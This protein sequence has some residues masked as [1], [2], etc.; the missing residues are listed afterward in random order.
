VQW[1]V[2][3]RWA[4]CSVFIAV[5]LWLWA[6]WGVARA[7]AP[8]P[9]DPDPDPAPGATASPRV[10]LLPV[11]FEG[12]DDASRRALLESRLREG[13][14]SG[15]ATLAPA[16]APAPACTEAACWRTL[17]EAHDARYVVLARIVVEA[18]VYRMTLD[19]YDD[20]GEGI[21]RARESCEV[22]GI[23]DVASLLHDQ[24]AALWVK[25]EDLSLA[26][27]VLDVRSEP[28]GATVEI[29]GVVVGL[30]P[31]RVTVRPG[32]RQ[33]EV[34]KQGFSVQ[35]RRLEAVGGTRESLSFTLTPVPDAPA[36]PL[37]PLRIAGWTAVG[38]AGAGVVTGTT[39]LVLDGREAT[40]RCSG[41]DRDA[42][43]TCRYLHETTVA[44]AISLS[45]AG[46]ATVVAITSAVLFRRRARSRGGPLA[47]RLHAAMP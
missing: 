30:T 8:S 33:V 11:V 18:R 36:R 40:G 20:R 10:V 9:P 39:L 2:R 46:V 26:V 34:R 42:F 6:G 25:L 15:G 35:A 7:G 23:A 32:S 27:P 3:Q 19:L 31:L 41:A 38:I 16:P 43:G 12:L 14:E 37:R 5:V 45:A 29:D 1:R 24:A 17:A 47:L 4:R 22:C 13:L 44:A 28:A 21:V